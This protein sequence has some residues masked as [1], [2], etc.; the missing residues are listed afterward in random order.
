LNTG[1]Y[2]NNI[3]NDLSANVSYNVIG[4]RIYIVGNVQ[5]PSVW[6]NG[7]N[8]ID[9]QVCKKIKN[10]ELKLNFKD[11][12]AQDL[13]YFQDLNGNRK[14]DSSDNN[15]QQINFGQTVTLSAKFNF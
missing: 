1:L 4:P 3:N 9:L 8:V 12:I 15:W 6:E 13:V 5:E 11:I 10:W 2:W 14:L 7:R